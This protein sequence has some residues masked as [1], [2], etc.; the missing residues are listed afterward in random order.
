MRIWCEGHKCLSLCIFT[1][2]YVVK[3]ILSGIAMTTELFTVVLKGPSVFKTCILCCWSKF[4]SEMSGK[5]APKFCCHSRTPR[6]FL[7]ES[8]FRSEFCYQADPLA[9]LTRPKARFHTIL[10]SCHSRTRFPEEEFTELFPEGSGSTSAE[11]FVPQ[12]FLLENHHGTRFV[13]IKLE[14]VVARS[15]SWTQ[16]QLAFFTFHLLCS[17]EDLKAGLAFLKRKRGTQHEGPLAFV[18]ANLTTFMDCQDTLA[19]AMI[20]RLPQ[21][22]SVKQTKINKVNMY[23]N[24][25]SCSRETEMHQML[26]ND[27]TNSKTGSC[28]ESLEEVLVSEYNSFRISS[29]PQQIQGQHLRRSEVACLSL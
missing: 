22:S 17:F 3:R 14:H 19:G 16:S 4:C 11:N 5:Y 15:V 23:G 28:T 2:A 26:V 12:W 24:C 8:I 29:I 6:R 25:F 18:K 7:F 27:Q 9:V 1:D 20:A 21:L 10:C 13:F